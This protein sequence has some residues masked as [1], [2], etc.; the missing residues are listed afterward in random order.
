[1]ARSKTIL[2]RAA[3]GLIVLFL[4]SSAFS[5]ETVHQI[6]KVTQASGEVSRLEYPFPHKINQVK[7]NQKFTTE[8]SY[9]AQAES[10]FTVQLFDGS[11][12]RLSPK[13]KMAAQFDPDSK[14]ITIHLFMGSI[15]ALFDSTRNQKKIQKFVIKS[16]HATFETTEAKFTVS[17]NVIND[18]SS[19]YVEKGVVLA[20]QF[21][22]NRKTDSELIHAKE[23]L[24]IK[25][26]EA[27]IKSPTKMT[28]N[29]IK[30]L[31]PSFYLNKKENDLEIK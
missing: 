18:F 24:S 15:K 26:L 21:I 23:M 5:A 28:D 2:S 10:Y 3:C 19:V 30:F 4:L 17:R 6:G 14:T 31:H 1:M 22:N 20:A 8:A 11:W 25:D 12:L 9:L 27:D 16:A 13:S 29:Q 7:V